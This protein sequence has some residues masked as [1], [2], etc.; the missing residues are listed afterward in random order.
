MNKNQALPWE[1]PRFRNWIA[2]GR[3]C[4]V[5]GLTLTRALQPLDL[6]PPHLDILVNLFR[7]PGISQQDLADKLLVGRSNLSMLLPQL[8]KRGLIVRRGDARDRRILRL[9]LTPEGVSLTK[10]A[11]VIQSELIDRT[12]KTASAEECDLVGNVMLRIIAELT[13]SGGSEPREDAEAL[14]KQG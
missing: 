4:Q 11:I 8:E 6:K 9:E 14:S 10:E 1:N 13:S 3:A 12:M 2:V 7:T 5:M